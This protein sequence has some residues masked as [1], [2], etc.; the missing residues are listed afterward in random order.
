MNKKLIFVVILSVAIL[1][2]CQGNNIP[3]SK[4]TVDDSVTKKVVQ[5]EDRN[6][7]VK[8][9]TR[10]TDAPADLVSPEKAYDFSFYNTPSLI[11]LNYKIESDNL[12]QVCDG[13]EAS[14]KAVGWQRSTT[15]MNSESEDNI[16]RA[17]INGTYKLTESCSLSD[18]IP[19][20]VLM[21]S[22]NKG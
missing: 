10:P 22:V 13:I 20:I 1:A 16:Y 12:V 11:S 5:V 8:D 2:G 21:K 6:S 17:F 3:A 15:G 14:L 9:Y 7:E 19:Y 4:T 18:G